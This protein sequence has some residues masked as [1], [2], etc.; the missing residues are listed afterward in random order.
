LPTPEVAPA[1]AEEA[2]SPSGISSGRPDVHLETLGQIREILDAL[3]AT[4]RRQDKESTQS[5]RQYKVL[6]QK[7]KWFSGKFDPEK[8]EG[9]LNS[10][11]AQGWVL[12]SMATASVPGFGGNREEIVIVMER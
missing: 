8:V 11:A 2:I 10:Y 7:D 9:A 4:V 3:L 5:N 6:T 12:K 1:R